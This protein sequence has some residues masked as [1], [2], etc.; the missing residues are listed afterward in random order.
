VATRDETVAIRDELDIVPHTL[1]GLEESYAYQTLKAEKEKLM[2][3]LATKVLL[4]GG[5]AG[6]GL[7]A[8]TAA[9]ADDQAPN[10]VLHY[11][12]DSLSSDEGV[13]IFY[14]R[15][16]RAAERVCPSI[17]KVLVSDAERACREQAI[18]KVVEKINNSK[19]AALAPSHGP[20]KGT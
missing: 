9:V 4:M 1:R 7:T 10:V 5:L 17:D 2:I 13:L 8:G 12:N 19:L 3:K 11:S 15:L 6:L 16:V 14:H 18:A 20:V